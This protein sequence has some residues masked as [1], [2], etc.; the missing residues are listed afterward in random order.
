MNEIKYIE[1]QQESQLYND[2]CQII[3]G[4]RGRIA[5]Y[6]NTEACLTNWY[7]GKRIKED[8]LYETLC[9]QCVPFFGRRNSVRNAYPIELDPSSFSNGHQRPP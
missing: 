2:V 5:T 8:I 9:T 7:V 3:D 4:A 1:P 6:V